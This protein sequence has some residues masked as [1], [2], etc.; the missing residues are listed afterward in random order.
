MFSPREEYIIKDKKFNLKYFR[1]Y[2]DAFI[3]R[4]PYQRKAGI[5]SKKK[6]I[7][8]LDSLCKRYYIPK[9]VLREV[10][11]SE[12]ETKYEV[13]DGQQRITTILQ[14]YKNELKLP[15]SLKSIDDSGEI[16][17]KTHQEL[18][19][20]KRR[21][22]DEDLYLDADVIK[23]IEDKN[24]IEQQKTA[25]QIF[26]RLQQGEPL[27]FME[28][29]H[30]KI[31]SSVRNFVTEYADDIS[32]D[33]DLYKPKNSNNNRLP[34]FAKILDTENNRMQHLALLSRFL[35][36]EFNNGPTDL[37]RPSLEDFFNEYQI[38]NN[39]LDNKKFEDKPETK[40]CLKNL[41]IFYKIFQ[42]ENMI[43]DENGV[44]ELKKEYFVISLYLLLRHL[45]EYYVFREE[46]FETF[47]DFTVS[48]YKRLGEKDI[49][50]LDILQFRDKRQQSKDDVETRDQILRYIFFKE[51]P[52]LTL[53]DT[54]RTFN[55]A[56]RIEIY[57]RDKGI[58]K[59]CLAEGI[60]E[61]EA[62]VSWKEYD[63][64]HIK[65][66]TKGGTTSLENAQVLC[67]K[68]N[69]AKQDRDF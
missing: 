68:H 63:A 55:E 57:R 35:L 56:E 24:N 42:N 47:R 58:C 7:D 8:F 54:K 20:E 23:N 62:V 67:K 22:L 39:D 40:N 14:F 45:I 30:S 37:G 59:Q 16:V 32:F 2:P 6:K 11:F 25:S 15:E 64:D 33:R 17:N 27:T 52:N 34:F 41:N 26:W 44:K 19:A 10:R 5:W 65:A 43:D 31:Y 48:F 13:I 53:K 18:S 9:I 69:R 3:L 50:D 49:D 28:T 12:D 4:P 60:N 46:Q 1:D 38:D 29:L 21:W 36:I 61:K 66:F 51:N